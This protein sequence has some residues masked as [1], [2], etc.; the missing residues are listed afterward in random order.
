MATSSSSNYN[1]TALQIITEALELTG[2]YQS[3]ETISSEDTQSCLQSLNMMVK[4]WQGDG[5]GLWK[6]VD[7]MLFL[8]KSEYLY[9]IG[10]TGDHCTKVSDGVKTEVATAAAS[11]ATS[12][13]IDA[14]TGMGDTFDR[15]GIITAVTPAAAGAITLNGALVAGGIAYLPSQREILIYSSGNDS[16][17][18]FAIVGKDIHG[19]SV[20]ETITGPNTTTVYSTNAYYTVSS[21]SI[22]G[23]GTGSI[24]VGCVGDFVGIEL[25][26]GTLQWTNIGAALSTTLVLVDALTDDVAVDNHVYS[27]TS[28]LERPIS[29]TDTRLRS[30]DGTERPLS[31]KSRQ[32]YMSLSNKEDAGTANLVYYDPQ[33]TNGNLYFWMACNDVKEYVKFTARIPIEDF[34]SISN[35][36]D[37]PQEWLLALSWNLA[38]IISPKFGKELSTRFE[39][40]ALGYKQAVSNFDREDTS[41]FLTI[42]DR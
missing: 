15:N 20:T 25:D 33:L 23:V 40:R 19:A 37:F 26:D 12:V 42:S 35:D 4:A 1:R 17:V 6:N 2:A 5:I 31:I 29:I 38:T 14:T 8:E 11:G 34:D 36:P 22:S 18:T 39:M 30:S 24:E 28:K 3:G 9:A 41:I 13:V 7:A 10:P 16:G 21:V 32:E 27:Y